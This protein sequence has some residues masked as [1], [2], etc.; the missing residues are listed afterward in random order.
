MGIGLQQE[1][2]FTTDVGW[3]GTGKT[4]HRGCGGGV[5]NRKVERE[6]HVAEDFEALT[7]DEE[8][9]PAPPHSEAGAT[10]QPLLS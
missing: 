4:T 7:D 1:R 6:R 2:Q 5:W 10:R 8:L 9:L 3:I